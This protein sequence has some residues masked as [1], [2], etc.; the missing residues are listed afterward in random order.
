MQF[1]NLVYANADEDQYLSKTISDD[2][3]LQAD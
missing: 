3:V 1:L 2:A